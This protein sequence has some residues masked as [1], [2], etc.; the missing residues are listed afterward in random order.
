MISTEQSHVKQLAQATVAII[1]SASNMGLYGV[2]GVALGA[3]TFFSYLY[4]G[5][6][7]A[8][9][10]QSKILG[11][12]RHIL[13]Y[14]VAFPVLY[15]VTGLCGL[16]AIYHTGCLVYGFYNYLSITYAISNL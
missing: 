10:Y 3:L 9:P 5:I 16:M 7:G 13:P 8:A 14:L 11:V 12:P 1:S 6:C 2:A 4:V 15:G